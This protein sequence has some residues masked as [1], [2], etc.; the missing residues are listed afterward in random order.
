MR[1]CL[2]KRLNHLA[3]VTLYKL[4]FDA[5]IANDASH[6]FDIHS[7]LSHLLGTIQI[8]LRTSSQEPR[9]AFNGSFCIL[10]RCLGLLSDSSAADSD[11]LHMQ[12]MP[13]IEMFL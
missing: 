10:W 5:C 9:N 4:A 2:V 1:R 13:D 12:Q 8:F 6:R 3:H 7:C 11:D